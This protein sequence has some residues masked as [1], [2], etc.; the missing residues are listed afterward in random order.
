LSRETLP[1][2]RKDSIHDAIKNALVKDGWT[3]THDPYS[4]EFEDDSIHIDLAAELP[5]AAERGTEKIAVEIK[6]F[7]AVSKQYELYGVLGQYNAYKSV[8]KELDSER[9]LY[10]AVSHTIY[11]EAFGRGIFR[12]VQRDY[13]LNIIVVRLETEEIEQW[14]RQPDFRS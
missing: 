6:S 3:I 4:L 1:M 14:I 12:L 11:H 9:D 13:S 10:L 5:F 8:L 7:F 2:P